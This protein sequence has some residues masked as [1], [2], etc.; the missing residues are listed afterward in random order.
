MAHFYSHGGNLSCAA[1][2]RVMA[3]FYPI[4]F[5]LRREASGSLIF[6]IGHEKWLICVISGA[7][8]EIASENTGYLDQIA[9]KRADRRE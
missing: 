4:A 3:I 5:F 8:P 9:P 6:K 1:R 7:A 2:Q